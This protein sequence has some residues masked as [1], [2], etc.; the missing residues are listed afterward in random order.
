MIN[1]CKI[2]N[3]VMNILK[4]EH[5]PVSSINIVIGLF[6]IIGVLSIMVLMYLLSPVN[7][8]YSYLKDCIPLLKP[9]IDYSS[10]YI[11]LSGFVGI[12]VIL[13]MEI[14]IGV[15]I[16]NI[17]IWIILFPFIYTTFIF[18][19]GCIVGLLFDEEKS[20]KVCNVL[21]VNMLNYIASRTTSYCDLKK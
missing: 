8:L 11:F 10:K 13:F 19:L 1:F 14:L 17:I 16:N 7:K 15:S 21:L 4:D 2:Y 12:G 6:Q 5:K 18:V 20:N 3:K 9:G